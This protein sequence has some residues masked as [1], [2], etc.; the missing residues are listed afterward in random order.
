MMIP[1]VIMP[2]WFRKMNSM[3]EDPPYS[4]A[5]GYETPEAG[6][7]V[8]TQPVSTEYAMPYDHPQMVIDGIH[9]DLGENQGLIEV[10]GGMTGSGRRYLYS[11]VK[12][13][14]QPSGV[15]YCTTMHIEFPDCAVQVQGF[16]DELGTTGVRD[17]LVYVLLSQ[18]G[19]VKAT[20]DGLEGWSADP[21]DAA[22]KHGVCMNCSEEKKFDA[23]FPQHPLSEARRFVAELVGLN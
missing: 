3:P 9:R 10:E 16:F 12:T 22:Y 19:V 18:D 2:S 1:E 20:D 15:Q 4:K 7:F 23:Q 21:Y 11:I 8:M 14:N 5:Y 17:S 13:L 6:C